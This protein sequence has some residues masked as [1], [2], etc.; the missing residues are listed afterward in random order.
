[1]DGITIN[2]K[3]YIFLETSEAV[4][5]DKCDLDKDDM[6]NTSLICK[7]FHCLLHGYEG[8]VGV[9]KELKEEK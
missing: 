2:D 3:Q 5:C 8:E 9:F 4:D 6:C 1:M 7:H